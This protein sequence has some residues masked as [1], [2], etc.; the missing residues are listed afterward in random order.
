MR[1]NA[2]D[3]LKLETMLRASRHA[4]IVTH[5]KPDGDAL[6]SSFA[7]KTYLESLK[8][9]FR[10]Q[11]EVLLVNRPA[12]TLEFIIA[13]SPF[14][15]ADDGGYGQILCDADLLV[16]LDCSGLMRTE[17]LAPALEALECP[18]ILID[19]HIGPHTEEFDL[20]I[21]R[22]DVSSASELLYWLLKS[23][24]DIAGDAAKIPERSRM[25]LMAGMTTDT[26][27]FA[28]SV[29]PSTLE[30]AS[31]LLA[32]G[33]DRD[34][35]LGKI[36]NE[37]RENRLRLI[38]H[39]LSEVMKITA[40]G[41]AYTLLDEKTMKHFYMQEGELEGFVNMPLTIAKVVMSVFIRQDAEVYRVSIRSK[42]GVSAN[43]FS[44]LYFNGGGHEQAAGGRIFGVGSLAGLEKYLL[45]CI[46][47][48]FAK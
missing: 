14:H 24:S 10:R 28:N 17:S 1:F 22:T 5:A 18:K 3:I 43:R 23:F 8:D 46:S 11:A 7:L 13:G 30:M 9:G 35:I 4:L 40:E 47:D 42:R 45:S 21:S 31:E 2:E 37:Y 36:Y 27:N 12:P 33:V 48:F 20:V 29:F 38:G 34:Y 44:Q 25:A 19:H 32:T 15:V 26:N 16:C 6:G 39:L 41:V